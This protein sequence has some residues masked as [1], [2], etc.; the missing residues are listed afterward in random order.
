MSTSCSGTGIVERILP[1][2]RASVRVSRAEAC[3]SCESVGAC[4]ALGGQT[5]DHLLVLA[6]PHGARPGQTVTLRLPESSVLKASAMLYGLPALTLVG[7]AGAGYALAPSL[8]WGVDPTAA[9]GA[10][11]GLT[12]GILGVWILNKALGGRDT[13]LPTIGG[14]VGPKGDETPS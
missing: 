2:G 3:S 9:L 7:F 11:L 10:G 5:K 8:G 12:V 13:Y 1:D 14:I 4:Q 6:N